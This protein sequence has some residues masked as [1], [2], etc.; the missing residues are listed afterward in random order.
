MYKGAYGGW[1]I[2]YA[3]ER[4]CSCWPALY[5]ASLL[6]ARHDLTTLLHFSPITSIPRALINSD[7]GHRCVA[8]MGHG[9]EP[10]VKTVN[11]SSGQLGKQWYVS[12]E[13]SILATLAL[14]SFE[15]R[16]LSRRNQRMF[17]EFFLSRKTNHVVVASVINC[18]FTDD[19][20]LDGE[21]WM[22][23]VK[24]NYCRT[25][26]TVVKHGYHF[27]TSIIASTKLLR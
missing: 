3:T 25:L 18:S 12:R 27:S 16:S 21:N 2:S 9:R 11:T 8:A 20:S 6:M 7:L 24:W 13:S 10:A 22:Y 26:Q 19:V 17:V 4:G 1:D 14:R 15:C 23:F 5:L